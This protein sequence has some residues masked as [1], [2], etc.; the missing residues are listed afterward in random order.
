MTEPVQRNL[1][2]KAGIDLRR[3]DTTAQF[4]TGETVDDHWGQVYK[5]VKVATDLTIADADVDSLPLTFTYTVDKGTSGL[6]A[7][8]VNG[9]GSVNGGLNIST[10]IVAA[11]SASSDRVDAILERRVAGT[12]VQIDGTPTARFIWVKVKGIANRL[13]KTVDIDAGDWVSRVLDTGAFVEVALDEG[14]AATY[15]LG[16]LVPFGFCIA[17]HTTTAGAGLAGDFKFDVS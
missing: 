13:L 10:G 8:T 4:P 1:L 17:E 15:S 9:D 6:Q 3:T 14:G 11:A 12:G 7:G 2:R 5:Y 16:N